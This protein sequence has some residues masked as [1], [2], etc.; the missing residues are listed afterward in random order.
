V[1]FPLIILSIFS[2]IIYCFASCVG[3]TQE[4]H[5][6][7]FTKAYTTDRNYFV[8]DELSI[9]QL[10]HAYVVGHDYYFHRP[11][12]TGIS[13]LTGTILIFNSDISYKGPK[14]NG[15]LSMSSRWS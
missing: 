10:D 7:A 3:H 6:S 11:G 12:E 5:V 8:A 2:E 1:S 15:L 4:Q 9:F 13:S 14:H